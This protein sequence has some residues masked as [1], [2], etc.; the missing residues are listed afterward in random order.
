VCK[1]ALDL[2]DVVFRMIEDMLKTENQAQ[3]QDI[4]WNQAGHKDHEGTREKEVQQ[5]VGP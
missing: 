5:G 2:G 4:R 3:V 1:S